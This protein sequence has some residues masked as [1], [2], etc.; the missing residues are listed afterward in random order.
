M[1]GD[2]TWQVEIGQIIRVC[3]E[4]RTVAEPTPISEKRAASP[5]QL[6]FS[7]DIYVLRPWRTRDM[8]HHLFSEP[9]C[10]DE[11]TIDP[12]AEQK[13]EPVIQKWA[14]LNWYKTFWDC[15]SQ[16]T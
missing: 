7:D 13:I 16:G 14:S 3:N 15:G 4:K 8:R 12:A 2:E 10:V 5:E 6:F 11:S 9:V 1:R